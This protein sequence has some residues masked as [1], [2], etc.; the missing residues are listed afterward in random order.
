MAPMPPQLLAAMH[1]AVGGRPPAANLAAP[2]TK[3]ILSQLPAPVQK[4]Q[5]GERLFPLIARHRHDLAGKI[6][7][8]MLELNNSEIL[9]L[10]ENETTL[11]KKV[12]E[13]IAV[14]ESKQ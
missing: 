4:Q 10:L 3:E 5:L 12:D 1:A 6:T 8:M 13:A 14:L 2:L 11:K 9:R 7:G